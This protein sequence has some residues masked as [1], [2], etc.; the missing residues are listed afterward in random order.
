LNDPL[1]T[2][3]FPRPPTPSA[4]PRAYLVIL[5]ALALPLVLLLTM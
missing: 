1:I 3:D 4:D 5:F 2:D